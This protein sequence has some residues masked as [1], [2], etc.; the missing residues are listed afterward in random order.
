[1]GAAV[2]DGIEILAAVIALTGVA[3]ML[4]ALF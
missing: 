4:A 2:M 3:L 1:V